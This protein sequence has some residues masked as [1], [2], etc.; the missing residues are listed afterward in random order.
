M[1]LFFQDPLFEDFTVSLGL[2]LAAHGRPELG[3]VQATCADIVDGEDESWYSAW[4]GAADR[5]VQAGDASAQ[6]GHDVSARESYLR[7]CVCY[8]AAWHPLFGAPVEPRL[9]EA[10]RRQRAAFDKAAALMEFAR[11]AAG[12]RL[13]GRRV[14]RLSISGARG[15]RAAAIADRDQRI[16]QYDL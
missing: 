7:A 10:F 16:R 8:S 13:R 11:R 2:G 1:P 5:V 9:L 15:S 3:E 12:D 6:G 14:A 4:C